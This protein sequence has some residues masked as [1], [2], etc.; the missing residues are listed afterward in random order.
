MEAFIVTLPPGRVQSRLADAQ[1]FLAFQGHSARLSGAAKAVVSFRGSGWQGA[2]GVGQVASSSGV[3]VSLRPSVAASPRLRVPAS[4]C[5]RVTPSARQ[6][7][8]RPPGQA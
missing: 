4:P 6:S 5:P 7:S 1:A 8:P 2:G 3:S